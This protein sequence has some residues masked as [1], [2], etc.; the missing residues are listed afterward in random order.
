MGRGLCRHHDFIIMNGMTW[1]SLL[2]PKPRHL[3]RRLAVVAGVLPI[4]GWIGG[5]RWTFD[6][7]NH[8]QFQYAAFLS[9]CAVT[10]LGTKAFREAAIVAALLM[11]PLLRIAPSYLPPAE[12]PSAGEPVRVASFNVFVSNQR[13]EETLRWVRETDPDFIYFT[14]T[15]DTW[16]R[17]LEALGNTY[18]HSVEEGSGFAFYSRWPIVRHDIIRCSDIGFPLLVA[19]IATPRGEVTFFGIH[20]LPPVTRQWARALDETMAIIAREVSRESGPV[21]VAGDFNAT[22]WSHLSRPLH[23][24]GLMDASR[25]KAPGPTW[26]RSNALVTIPIDR[27][28]FRGPGT[29]CRSFA[30]GPDIGSDHRPLVAEVAW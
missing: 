1:R 19:R 16:T 12:A 7:F 27:I 13:H 3:I 6:L 22:R 5:G 4:I 20:P 30:I 10:L 17:A 2:F 24:T 25:G 21:I 18:P 9:L 8:F 15:T 23:R 29:S 11:V 14:E 28:L 26:M